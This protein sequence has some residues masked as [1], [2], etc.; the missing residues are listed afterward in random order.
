MARTGLAETDR[1]VSVLGYPVAPLALEEAA[2]LVVRFSR[3]RGSRLVVTL[4]PE[5]VV[6]ARREP[7]LERAI[8]GA[9][10]IVADGVGILWAARRQGVRLKGRVPGV[11]L[12]ERV[13]SLGGPELRAY[14]LGAKPGVAA[15]AAQVAAERWGTRVVGTQHGYFRRPDDVPAVLED[16]RRARPD[17]VLAGLGEGQERFL[18]E[19]VRP[20]G[21]PVSIGVGGT[22]DVLAGEAKRTPG[23]TRRLGLEWAWRVGL[24]PKRWHR[25]PRLV[26][27]AVIVLRSTRR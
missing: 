16:I 13:L 4:N 26:A 18:H 8:L 3:E 1:R 27:F 17:L 24:D 7:S 12:A 9:E 21:V 2:E 15:R 14:F 10:L 22:L 6:Q 23:W 5:I 25:I 20:L 19:H 11:E